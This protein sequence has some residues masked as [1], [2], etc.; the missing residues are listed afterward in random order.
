MLL[1]WLVLLIHVCLVLRRRVDRGDT[2]T[3]V[4]GKLNHL[5]FSYTYDIHTAT[6]DQGQAEG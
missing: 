5:R 3:A 2:E 4:V 6:W 1:P